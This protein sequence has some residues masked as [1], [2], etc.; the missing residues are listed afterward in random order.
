MAKFDKE[1]VQIPLRNHRA[2]LHWREVLF[3]L[4][5]YDAAG[6]RAALA[7]DVRF[8]LQEEGLIRAGSTGSMS[9][10]SLLTERGIEMLDALGGPL[11]SGFARAM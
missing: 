3:A 5:L 10:L 2:F 1:S 6:A 8:T 11:P 7:S 9:T 4:R